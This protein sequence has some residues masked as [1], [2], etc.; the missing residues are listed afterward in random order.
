MTPI[1]KHYYFNKN[2]EVRDIEEGIS[3]KK[4]KDNRL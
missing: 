1:E 4:N 2:L 3:R